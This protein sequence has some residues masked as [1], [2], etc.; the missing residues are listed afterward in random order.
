MKNLTALASA[1]TLGLASQ[2]PLRAADMGGKGMDY[3]QTAFVTISVNA[4]IAADRAKVWKQIIRKDVLIKMIGLEGA[5]GSE[6]MGE[7]GSTLCGRMGGEAGNL[8]VTHAMIDNEVR[9][10]WEPDHGGYVCH[11]TLK[12]TPMGKGTKV[13]LTDAYSEEK[14]AM[15]EKN[16]KDTRMHLSQSLESLKKSVTL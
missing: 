13:T 6:T 8:V 10:S 2:A 4:D 5:T 12:L 7:P 15:L 16:A 14:P 11:I 9:Y 1:L 3:T